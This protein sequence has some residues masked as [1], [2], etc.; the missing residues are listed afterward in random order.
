MHYAILIL[1]ILLSLP[2][3]GDMVHAE[4][5]WNKWLPPTGVAVRQGNAA[6]WSGTNA[7]RTDGQLAGEVAYVW[8]DT[9][10]GVRGIAMQVIDINGNPKFEGNGIQ[11]FSCDFVRMEPQVTPTPDGGWIVAWQDYRTDIPDIYYTKVN[12]EGEPI[13]GVEDLGLT[14]NAEFAYFGIQIIEAG[15]G[16]CLIIW[17]TA[18]DGGGTDIYATHVM[19]NGNL[20]G[21]WPE[22]G[23]DVSCHDFPDNYYS[24]TTDGDNGFILTWLH[25]Q[26]RTIDIFAQRVNSDGTLLWGEGEAIFVCETT[27]V[28]KTPCIASDGEGGA[29]IC[30]ADWRNLEENAEDIYVQRVDSDGDFYW[31]D[32]G[33]PLASGELQQLNPQIVS[34]DPGTVV[35]AWESNDLVHYRPDI[36]A[37]MIGGEDELQL[38]WDDEEGIPIAVAENDQRQVSIT[39]DDENGILF[40]WADGRDGQY[41]SEFDIWAQR[42]DFDG[43][44]VWDENGVPVCQMEESQS[45]PIINML[46]SDECIVAWHPTEFFSNAA[47]K[48]QM[49][50]MDGEPLGEENGFDIATGMY[51]N[52]R[53]SQ[54]ISLDDDEFAVVWSDSRS[55]YTNGW[56]P[57]VQFYRDNGNGVEALFENNGIPVIDNPGMFVSN[58]I[59]AVED[60]EGGIIV[61]WEENNFRDN[62]VI[63]GQRMNAE[64]ERL[65]GDDGFIVGESEM[66]LRKTIA[67][68]DGENGAYFAFVTNLEPEFIDQIFV[69]HVDQDGNL[70][71]DNGTVGFSDEEYDCNLLQLTL[72]E[73]GSVAVLWEMDLRG[74]EDN[75]WL[76]YISED[77]EQL[78]GEG[79]GHQ[80]TDHRMISLPVAVSHPDGIAVAWKER[81]EGAPGHDFLRAQFIETDGRVRWEQNGAVVCDSNT[82][83]SNIEM[84]VDDDEYIWIVWTDGRIEVDGHTTFQ[85]FLQKIEVVV[86][87][88]G[89]RL[90]L[91]EGGQKVTEQANQ[92]VGTRIIHDG[93]NG[94]WIAWISSPRDQ[95]QDI[96][97]T[98]LNP[99]GEMYEN[100]DANGNVICDVPHDQRLKNAA[101]LQESGEGGIVLVWD[102]ERSSD[103]SGNHANGFCCDDGNI[104]NNLY[105]QRVDDFAPKSVKDDAGL[106][107]NTFEITSA[108]PSPFNGRF[109]FNVQLPQADIVQFNLYDVTGRELWSLSERFG[110]GVHRQSV[111]LNLNSAGVYLLK[112]E[113]SFGSDIQRVVMLK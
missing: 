84:T 34:A 106:T 85:L 104:F 108:Y 51:G 6:E 109:S 11:L 18:V 22:G 110:V 52:A 60:G 64:G 14:V 27:A 71:W 54:L 97:A 72:G 31:E 21:D 32:G 69:N 17:G 98:H 16:G 96:L 112:A 38:L 47:I 7:T 65:W 44:I 3:I 100:W 89:P 107:P 86:D 23:L 67:I 28:R 78:W 45:Y 90:L 1:S 68:S 59:S 74:G 83:K 10:E 95:D 12:S 82:Y 77:G 20:D 56:I 61:L 13:W 58:S 48:A 15:Q 25:A 76:S 63:H 5:P 26:Q 46:G 93:D 79:D 30:W 102:D 57:M 39:Y 66:D 105:M 49:F 41:P 87:E 55:A 80:I 9:R 43:E 81:Q 42:V 75:L 91:E 35:V 40:T 94:V 50:D 24:I 4:Q 19:A 33:V 99:D 36:Y 101:L 92:Q 70:I 2:L 111:D 37:M 53:N 88:I 29:F 8:E 103:G 62:F 73:D 113:S